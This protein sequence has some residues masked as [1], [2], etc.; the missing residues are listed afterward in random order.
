MVNDQAPPYHP[1]PYGTDS[2]D[3]AAPS[4]SYE[5]DDLGAPPSSTTRPPLPLPS[6][7]SPSLQSALALD[8]ATIEGCA[9]K[10]PPRK[11]FI[12]PW[13]F[14]SR[15]G[16][17]IIGV[18]LLLLAGLVGAMIWYG[19]H[20]SE[21]KKEEEAQRI[22]RRVNAYL[23]VARSTVLP[24]V[25]SA[26]G[27]PDYDLLTPFNFTA[28]L[29]SQLLYNDAGTDTNFTIFT[30][31]L[32]QPLH[33]VPSAYYYFKILGSRSSKLTF[34]PTVEDEEEDMI[35]EVS[36]IWR[37][38]E[39]WNESESAA[40]GLR[41]LE[42][43]SGGLHGSN[44]TGASSGGVT[45]FRLVTS[46]SNVSDGSYQPSDLA[47]PFNF[48]PQWNN[49][50]VFNVT[51]QV[52]RSLY[53]YNLDVFGESAMAVSFEDLS[54]SN[55][56]FSSIDV[57]VPKGSISSSGAPNAT[58]SLSLFSLLP[59]VGQYT[60]TRSLLFI[61]NST[62]NTVLYVNPFTPEYTNNGYYPA[63]HNL[64]FL[65]LNPLSRSLLQTNITS[66]PAHANLTLTA[67]NLN[68]TVGVSIPLD[69]Y[70]GSVK[71]GTN[72]GLASGSVASWANSTE[73][74]RS[75]NL[76]SLEGDDGGD[77]W[78]TGLSWAEGEMVW[79]GEGGTNVGKGKGEVVLMTDEGTVWFGAGWAIWPYRA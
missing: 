50:L 35:V 62:I 61:S 37:G 59:I 67:L 58:N 10:K 25:L 9:P 19:V 24:G 30:S 31:S 12:P 78:D 79:R 1:P 76:Q 45:G 4:P 43:V 73:Y 38:A 63:T 46:S 28:P 60:V 11:S 68:G 51:I 55:A 27:S 44:W 70:E 75:P 6:S 14:H 17:G 42:T 53:G 54:Q 48:L 16:K 20:Q 47:T 72:N 3:P 69:V 23:G 33:L 22:D 5:L 57:R 13:L 49:T 15:K 32:Q 39:G 65:Q 52:P 40:W 77:G 34:V 71:V 29:S 18:L 26:T 7:S 36:A 21:E 56:T 66:F 8:D 41:E 74:P 2:H 64:T